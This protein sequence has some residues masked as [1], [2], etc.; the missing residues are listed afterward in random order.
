MVRWK[1]NYFWD[2]TKYLKSLNIFDF[3]QLRFIV[4][5][6]KSVMFSL[7]VHHL[8]LKGSR[9]ATGDFRYYDWELVTFNDCASENRFLYNDV[10]SLEFS[11]ST[12]IFFFKG[13]PKSATLL[14]LFFHTWKIWYLKKK[15]K[16]KL[17]K[18][19]LNS[20]WQQIGAWPDKY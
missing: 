18:R 19:V 10:Y 11:F 5:F 13:E 14:E 17:M 16:K 20:D 8:I 9:G 15:K 7:Q 6:L 4:T 1:T 3:I 2:W 12:S